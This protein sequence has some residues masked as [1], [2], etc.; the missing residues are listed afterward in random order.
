MGARVAG[1][2]NDDENA[3]FLLPHSSPKL[4][5]LQTH[6]SQVQG[7]SNGCYQ[8]GPAERPWQAA[9]SRTPQHRERG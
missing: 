2:H 5:H 7:K 4:H 3:G 9:C 6:G 1:A 8:S